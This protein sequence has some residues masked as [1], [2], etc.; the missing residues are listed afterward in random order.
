MQ[1]SAPNSAVGVEPFEIGYGAGFEAQEDQPEAVECEVVEHGGEFRALRPP[2]AR[3]PRKLCFVDG[4]MRAEARLTR[5]GDDG[6]TYRGLAGS[7]AAGAVLA[8]ATEAA[9]ISRVESGR[10]VIFTGGKV[11][12]LPRHRA[13]WGWEP[14]AVEGE[15]FDTARRR[16]RTMM[17]E[18]EAPIA[19]ELCRTGWLVVFDGPLHPVR[20]SLAASGAGSEGSAGV[21]GYVKTHHRRMLV[22]EQWRMVPT[23]AAGERSSLFATKVGLY[24]SYLRVGDAGPCAGAWSGIARLEVP[25]D[26]GREAAAAAVDEAASWLPQFASPLHRDARAPV[27]L[28][29]VSGLENQLRRRL[30]SAR[31][32]MRAVREAVADLNRVGAAGA[33]GPSSVTAGKDR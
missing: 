13:G 4:V 27:N 18:A 23:L 5:T 22:R 16:L 14:S 7:W 1:L 32:A 21:V 33:A 15:D 17:R 31:M 10:V 25:G 26:A 30:G 8:A 11:V 6:E 19:E 3:R 28:T 9:T 29:P 24:A 20:R 2:P 12:S